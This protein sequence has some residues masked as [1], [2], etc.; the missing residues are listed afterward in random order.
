MILKSLYFCVFF[1]FCFFEGITQTNKPVP[2]THSLLFAPLTFHSISLDFYTYWTWGGENEE[3]KKIILYSFLSS[4]L[5]SEWINWSF[6]YDSVEYEINFNMRRNMDILARIDANYG[7]AI[8]GALVRIIECLLSAS[9]W[10]TI[11][12]L[13]VFMSFVVCVGL[14]C[15]TMAWNGHLYLLF[16]LPHSIIWLT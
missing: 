8:F 10:G 3:Q 11:N 14:W 1:S 16:T 7:L 6:V 2:Y 12:I 13:W 9:S 5:L 15:W 4:F